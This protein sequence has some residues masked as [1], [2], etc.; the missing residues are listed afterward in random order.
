MS[1]INLHS[2][3]LCLLLLTA[4]LL[5]QPA[6]LAAADGD[7]PR[8]RGTR[9]ERFS[10][11]GDP[12]AWIRTHSIPLDRVSGTGEYS[13]LMPLRDE[14]SSAVIVGLGDN[15]HGTREFFQT[16]L[17]LIEFLV[18]EMDFTVI[19]FEGPWVAFARIDD[20]VQGETSSDP[21]ALLTDTDYWFWN[22]E[23]IAEVIAWVRDYNATRG[24]HEPVQI[25]GVDVFSPWAARHDVVTYLQSVDPVAA[26][27]AIDAYRCLG[28]P[29]PSSCLEGPDSVAKA[30]EA[31]RDDYVARS[32]TRRF[33]QVLQSARVVQQTGVFMSVSPRD[34]YEVRDASMAQNLGWLH[35]ESEGAPRKV[36]YWG[37][38]LHLGRAPYR[39]EDGGRTYRSAGTAL[40]ERFGDAYYTIATM[41]R[42][43]RFVGI[44]D[45]HERSFRVADIPA[46][47]EDSYETMFGLAA[48]PAMIVPLRSA[49][50]EVTGTR[51]LLVMYASPSWEIFRSMNLARHY[52]AVLYLDATSESTLLRSGTTTSP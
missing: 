28:P 49:P 13:D 4:A 15:S 40:A 3:G 7:S 24:T 6:L 48:A 36:I 50:P 26:D 2:R 39:L 52:D 23:E 5:F 10:E 21:R 43:G 35:A 41:T 29:T 37:H 47:S 33:G 32:S 44:V 14:L 1:P 17:R 51:P 42:K 45:G 12:L 27:A 22:T 34:G 9:L 8:R 46:L 30:M 25:A 18:R 11:P 19:A 31:K 38:N 20:M 16:K